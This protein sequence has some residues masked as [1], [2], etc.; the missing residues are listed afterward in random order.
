MASSKYSVIIVPASGGKSAQFS[1]SKVSVYL[2]GVVLFAFLAVN[3]FFSY[4]FLTKSYQN[5]AIATLAEE[6]EFLVSKITSFSNEIELLK[7]D[8]AGMIDR[9]MEI[10]TI[11]DL[12]SINAQDRALGIGGPLFLPDESPSVSRKISYDTENRLD[13]LVRLSSFEA[14]QYDTI[15]NTLLQ[16]KKTLDHLPSIMP[17]PGYKTRGFGVRSDPFTGIKRMHAG[18]DICNREGTPIYASAD[19]KVESIKKKGQLGRTVII[20]HDNGIQTYY[21]HILKATVK[22]GQIVKRGDKIAEMGNS[23]RSSGPHLHYAIKINGKWVN[24]MNYIFNSNWLAES[25]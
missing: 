8:Y 14:E 17:A 6:N 19:G 10:R 22:R 11:F 7:D 18:I 12:P 5:I 23:G 2:I 24:P 4:G 13:E 3:A 15:Y 21:G 20:N 1:I 16:K 25:N 9:E